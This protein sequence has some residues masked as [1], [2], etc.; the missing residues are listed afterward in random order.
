[1]D[2][3]PSDEAPADGSGPSDVATRATWLRRGA[4]LALAVVVGV[5]L[6]GTGALDDPRAMVR[7]V[8][9]AGAW[10][11]IVYL[12][13]FSLLQP[14]G[15]SGHVF[16]LSAGIVWGPAAGFALALLGGLGAASVGFLFARYVAF[17][18]VQARIPERLRRYEAWLVDRGLVGMVL[19]RTLTFTAPAGQLLVGTLRVPYGTMI[20]GT[21]VG[22][23]PGL[24]IDVF[25][26]GAVWEWL[27]G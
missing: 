22:L 21:A 7:W 25:L 24:A 2:D 13:A 1:V 16:T 18:W 11:V 15:L 19:F 4:A 27:F 12:A 5:T 8:R 20:L 17:D 6:W 14:F 26:G 9:D 10:G 23:L 3:S